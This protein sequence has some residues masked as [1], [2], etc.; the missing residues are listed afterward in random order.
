VYGQVITEQTIGC[1]KNIGSSYVMFLTNFVLMSTRCVN[2]FQRKINPHLNESPHEGDNKL[3]NNGTFHFI[4]GLLL[5]FR[6][7]IFR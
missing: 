4:P 7:R 3:K 6:R 5:A 2:L 1:A